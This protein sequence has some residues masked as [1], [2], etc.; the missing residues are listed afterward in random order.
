MSI[1]M[2]WATELV[3]KHWDDNE[4]EDVAVVWNMVPDL[5]NEVD[6]LRT[7]LS[8]FLAAT[9]YASLAVAEQSDRMLSDEVVKLRAE[10]AEAHA[11]I[12]RINRGWAQDQAALVDMKTEWDT[13]IETYLALQSQLAAARADASSTA[14]WI[15]DHQAKHDTLRTLVRELM[16]AVE[17]HGGN[18]GPLYADLIKRARAAVG[19]GGGG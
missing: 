16:D 10:L 11:D 7:E 17:E 2:S 18:L 1:E 12:A 5:C 9:G 6:R 4:P 8:A 3:M 13:D 19:G 15:Q 14:H